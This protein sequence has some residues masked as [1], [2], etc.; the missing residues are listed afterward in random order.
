MSVPPYWIYDCIHKGAIAISQDE[1]TELYLFPDLP[2]TL[3][4]LQKLK[5]GE[6]CNLR[7]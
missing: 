5:V 1:A 2:E 4:Q 6:I 3:K 7:F